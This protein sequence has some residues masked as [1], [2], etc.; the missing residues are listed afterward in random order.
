MM[1]AIFLRRHTLSVCTRSPYS[2]QLQL[3]IVTHKFS[4]NLTPSSAPSETSIC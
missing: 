2:V 3:M 4:V 1:C